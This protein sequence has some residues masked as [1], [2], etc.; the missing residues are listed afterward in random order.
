MPNR[1][2]FLNMHRF[3]RPLTALL[4]ALACLSAPAADS[5]QWG[6]AWSRNMVSPETGLVEKFDLATGSGIQWRVNLGTESHSSPVVAGGRIYIGT[7]NGKPRDPK[8]QGDRGVM[9][10][11]DEKDGHLLWQLIVPKRIEDQYFDWPNTGM[12]SPATVQGD[13]VY[14]VTSR[15]EV[16]CMD[17]HGMANG[18]DGPYKDEGRH[19]MPADHA[20]V[21][22]GPLDADIL[23]LYDLTAG[24]GI[25]SHDGAHS[26]IL[27]HDGLLYLNSGNGVDN[28]HRV[29]RRPDAPGLVV[30]DQETGALVA[31]D[32]ERTSPETFHCTWSPPSLGVVNGQTHI[33]FCGGNGIVYAFEPAGK[34]RGATPQTL[35]KIWQFDPDPTA[36]KTEVHRYTQNRQEGPSDIFALPVLH[37]G[38]LFVAGGGDI[39]WGKSSSWIKCIT[40]SGSGDI[41]ATAGVWATALGNHVMASP[42]IHQGL[43][44]LGDTDGKFYCLDAATGATRWTHDCN[45]QFWA[46]PLLADGRLYVGTRRGDHYIFAAGAEKKLLHQTKFPSPISATSCAANGT[47]YISTMTE[48]LALKAEKK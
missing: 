14:T 25:W 31:R 33:F 26:S 34:E 41:T 47:L 30:L 32:Q 1:F 36:P 21:E 18:N 12:S 37:E 38:R 17:V 23:W 44:Y 22:P 16:V 24:A 46:T 8:H 42:V 35:K 5:P 4:S 2:P 6:S 11:F 43:V 3:S 40:P 48:L 19:M 15:G 39:W 28:T 9:M 7:N 27:I 29:I 13:R 20:A 45:G 10:C